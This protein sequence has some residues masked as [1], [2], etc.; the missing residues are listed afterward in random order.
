MG[1]PDNRIAGVPA[2]SMVDLKKKL[3]SSLNK[4]S[5]CMWKGAYRK[6]QRKEG[7]YMVKVHEDRAKRRAIAD[8]EAEAVYD[9]AEEQQ[10]REYYVFHC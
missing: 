5:S 7:E 9:A 2:K 8:A 4:I 6:V 1:H 3:G 10:G